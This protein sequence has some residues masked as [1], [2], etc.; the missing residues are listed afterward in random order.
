MDV[1]KL[2]PTK[3]QK[4][5]NEGYEG[6][7]RIKSDSKVFDWGNGNDILALIRHV[8]F[9]MLKK[10]QGGVVPPFGYRGLKFKEELW[11]NHRH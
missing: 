6:K 4:E 5:L 1:S 10:Y 9:E 8:K 11:D 2:Q 7:Q 3:F